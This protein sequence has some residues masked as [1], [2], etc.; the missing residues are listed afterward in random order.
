MVS[1]RTEGACSNQIDLYASVS[2]RRV[3]RCRPGHGKAVISAYL[4]ANDET[5]AAA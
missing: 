1:R 2:L 3:P 4:V 5:C